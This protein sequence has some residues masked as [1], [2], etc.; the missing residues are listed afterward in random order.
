M[1]T[2]LEKKYKDLQKMFE[3]KTVDQNINFIIQKSIESFVMQCDNPAI[4]CYGRHTR[5][6]M[7]D[8]MFE[9]KKVCYIIDNGMKKY[10]E[11]GFEIIDESQIK[12]KNIDGIIVSSRIHRDEIIA[13]LKA[14]YGHI[15]YLDIYEELQ[16][17]G[18]YIQES[19]YAINHPYSK[20]C[21]LNE[22]QRRLTEEK[23]EEVF[24]NTINKIVAKYIE[25][26]DF[27]SAISY[28]QKLNNNTWKEKLLMLLEEIYD[29]Q[30]KSLKKIESNNIVMLCIDGLRRKDICNEYMKNLVDFLISKTYFFSNAYSVS[31]STYESLIPTYSENV[32]LRSK[33]Y[34]INSISGD[35]CRFIKEAKKQQRSIYFYTDGTSYICDREIIVTERS[36]TATEKLWDFLLDSIDE[37]NGLFYIHILYESHFSYPN[38]YTMDKIIADGTSIWFDYLQRNGGEVRT[39]YDKQHKDAL[40]Y[41][42]NVIVPLIEKIP[43]RLVLFADHGNVLINKKTKISEIEKI[44]YT[45]HEDLIRVPLAIKSPEIPVKRD[46]SLISIIEL[47]TILIGLMNHKRA[48]IRKRKNIKVLRSEIYNPDFKYL[49]EKAGYKQGL[50]AFELFVFETGYKL[51]IYS[52]GTTECYYENIKSNDLDTKQ[53][54]LETVKEQVTVC[55]VEAINEK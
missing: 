51:A 52:D 28:A 2:L 11:S 38:P 8:F 22:L 7:A 50:L 18:I 23:N 12:E 40:R 32:D 25:I 24:Q 42:D 39:D 33:Y 45:F 21:K 1:K 37:K 10:I 4:W 15:R 43:C 26:K 27:Q 35:N 6:L 3:I 16:K 17:A 49:Y 47:N 29:L 20:Y 46:D 36:Q 53:E 54:L 34:E 5:M 19:Y 30:K 44:K 41:L 31:T 13:N 9:L 55:R 14:N 48:Y